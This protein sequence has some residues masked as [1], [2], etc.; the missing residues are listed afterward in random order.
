MV[1]RRKSSEVSGKL[2]RG[3]GETTHRERVQ[4]NQGV[5]SF[6]CMTSATGHGY[7]L[8]EILRFANSVNNLAFSFKRARRC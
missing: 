8:V 7:L 6:M 3:T 2:E 4:R 1:A 5:V